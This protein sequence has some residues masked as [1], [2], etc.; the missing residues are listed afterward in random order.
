VAR[1]AIRA[2]WLKNTLLQSNWLIECVYCASTTD[3]HNFHSSEQSAREVQANF[4]DLP[5][6]KSKYNGNIILIFM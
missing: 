1:F 4:E 2:D 3:P 6:N 5:E